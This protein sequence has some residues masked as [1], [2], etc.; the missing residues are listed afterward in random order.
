MI[1]QTNSYIVPKEKRAEHARL[2]ARFR[3]SL[4][5]NGCDQFEVYE[6]TGPNWG[7]GE[8]GRFVQI[9][10]FRDR[11]HQQQVQTAERDDP[12]AQAL[13][14]EFCELVNFQYQ[15]QNGMF[16]VGYYTSVLAIAPARLPSVVE[17]M[18]A[19]PPPVVD[20]TPP[21]PSHEPEPEA[22]PE[23]LSAAS[24]YETEED[25][26]AGNGQSHA[27]P[28]EQFADRPPIHSE[29]PDPAFEREF[30]AEAE[31]EPELQ[32]VSEE[33]AEPAGQLQISPPTETESPEEP[34]PAA[35]VPVEPEPALEEPPAQEAPGPQESEF[36]VH[37]DSERLAEPDMQ[38]D[39]TPLL[40]AEP[41]AERE[42]DIELHA[43]PE[44]EP[45]V[46]PIHETELEPLLQNPA[47]PEP[48]VEPV[49]E[50]EHG[51]LDLESSHDDS[52]RDAPLEL[53]SSHEDDDLKP[54][55]DARHSK[56]PRRI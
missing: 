28:D 37:A 31:P 50:A 44:M 7:S 6:Q 3:Q 39:I 47:E 33:Q 19:S 34:E 51:T 38:V 29:I 14:K 48:E 24:I 10:R 13:I 46:E 8:S 17:P 43:T 16:M 52:D 36:L 1:L 32:P 30:P 56:S 49:S 54:P 12:G 11:K 25:S 45:L 4:A 21:F 27:P 18:T 2:L 22:A 5:R 40:C 23:P 53:D 41:D 20:E 35:H 9:M 15:Q 42:L 26:A 55:P